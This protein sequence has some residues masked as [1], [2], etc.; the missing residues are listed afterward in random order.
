MADKYYDKLL[1]N[2]Q[3]IDTS[4]HFPANLDASGVCSI[5]STYLHYYS[6]TYPKP[7]P[8][9]LNQHCNYQSYSPP[10]VIHGLYLVGESFSRALQLLYWITPPC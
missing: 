9:L 5:D 10:T 1:L 7:L 2:H 6:I 4:I 3:L 8:A